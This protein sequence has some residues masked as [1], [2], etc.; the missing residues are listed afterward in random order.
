MGVAIFTGSSQARVFIN[1]FDY[2]NDGIDTYE[3]IELAGQAGTSLED[4]DLVLVDQLGE[5]YNIIDL[6]DADFTF[7]D[8]T[9]THW[10]FFVLGTVSPDL[11]EASDYTPEGWETNEIQNG[12][13]DSVQLRFKP[14]HVNVHLLDYEGDNEHTSEDEITDLEDSN[15]EPIQSLYKTGVGTDF[16]HF[17]FASE[18]G[19][20]SPGALNDGQILEAVLSSTMSVE[21]NTR[22]L[23]QNVPNPFH[24]DT[25]I[26]FNL[27]LESDAEVTVYDISGRRVRRLVDTRLSAG[28]HVVLW[29]GL[30]DSGSG[31]ASGGYFYE[32]RVDGRVVAR[33][34]AILFRQAH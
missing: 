6:A 17:T 22:I 15:D 10:G 1:E 2:D 7:A 29:E 8:E 18:P 26:T 25:R 19:K 28:R 11:G 30:D 27:P 24:R 33:E 4:F 3:W 31:L 9:G 34:R 5:T 13:G 23:L 16:G 21:G 14:G 12:P 32:L 20:S